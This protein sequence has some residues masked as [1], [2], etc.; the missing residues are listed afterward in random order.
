MDSPMIVTNESNAV[1][2]VLYEI[3]KKAIMLQEFLQF[4]E[5]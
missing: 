5:F 4:T 3:K 1:Q 2:I